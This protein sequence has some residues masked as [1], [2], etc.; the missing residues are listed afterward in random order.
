M[1]IRHWG[2]KI[3]PGA[4]SQFIPVYPSGHIQTD[5]L[6]LCSIHVAPFRHGLTLKWHGV[7]EITKR[8]DNFPKKK[9]LCHLVKTHP[10]SCN[11][12][13]WIR[14]IASI[15]VIPTL[16]GSRL[17]FNIHV[18]LSNCLIVRVCNWFLPATFFLC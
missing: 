18:V 16:G 13:I 3:L 2:I 8:Q 5:W 9:P 6:T 1:C 14:D 4:I 12:L 11:I 7:T 10:S 15:W 17:C